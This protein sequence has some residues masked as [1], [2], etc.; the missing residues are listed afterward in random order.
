M[1]LHQSQVKAWKRRPSW[2]LA[3]LWLLALPACS[4]D[5]AVTGNRPVSNYDRMLRALYS[6]SVPLVQPAQLAATLRKAPNQVLLLDTRTPAEYQ[7]SHLQ[8]ARFVDFE[9][10][11]KQDFK[12]LPRDKPV[13]VYCSVGYR[14]ERVGERLKALGFKNVR[15]L[16]G[17]IF[18]WMNEGRPV[19][20]AQG[21][22]Q[23]I[24]PYSALWGTWLQRGTQ[25]YK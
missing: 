5:K 22:T 13:V 16:Y 25:V 1:A 3:A 12:D 10:F 17:G 11:E 2:L 9:T 8:G 4:Q 24:H 20:N 19:L 18:Q 6:E 15:N 23:N 7:V 21:P 14:S